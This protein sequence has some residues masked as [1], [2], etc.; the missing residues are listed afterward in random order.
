MGDYFNNVFFIVSLNYNLYTYFHT[1]LSSDLAPTSKTLQSFRLDLYLLFFITCFF[2]KKGISILVTIE[3]FLSSRMNPTLSQPLLPSVV[4]IMTS[5][6]QLALP[7]VITI[8]SNGETV[9]GNFNAFV[10]NGEP[11]YNY[12]MKIECYICIGTNKNGD[13]SSLNVYN[14][15]F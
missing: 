1:K 3:L 9:G 10:I 12:L 4:S 7:T 11:L 5:S 6:F 13:S 2:F 15:L 14:H 8:H